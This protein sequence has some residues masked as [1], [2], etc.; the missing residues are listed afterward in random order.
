[1]ITC[2]L[3]LGGNVGGPAAVAQRFRRALGLLSEAG[4][5]VTGRSSIYLTPAW[6]VTDQPAF[7]NAVIR[8]E[9]DLGP[10]ALLAVLKQVERQVGRQQ[11]QRWG[12]RELDLDLLLYGEQAVELSGLIIPHPGLLQR[13]FVVI[14]LLE[15]EPDVRMP[16][17]R[18][19]QDAALPGALE[20]Q[21][22]QRF[23]EE[24][25]GE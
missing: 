9:V 5:R 19:V 14:P 23:A 22:I 20:D 8:A 4:V 6:G 18:R 7:L 17:G 13:A 2:Y 11:R 1:M 12:P 24:K 25:W 16:D 15:L 10:E 3:A 21:E